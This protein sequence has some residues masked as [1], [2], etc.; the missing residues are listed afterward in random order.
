MAD[1]QIEVTCL[2]CQKDF[3]VPSYEQGRV[4]D[5]PRCYGFV[6]V[7][8]DAPTSPDV[9]NTED[10]LP[11]ELDELILRRVKYGDKS[12]LFEIYS[13]PDFT[14]Y[15]LFDPWTIEQTDDFVCSQ[16][17]IS[18][19]DTGVPFVL[20][21]VHREDNKVIGECQLSICPTFHRQ[22]E[23]GFGLNL[24]YA[25]RG[26]ATKMVNATLRFGFQQL[27]LHRITAAADVR[28]ERSWRL[29]ERL[30]MRREAHFVH[31]TYA[32]DEWVDDYVYAM[33]DEE[34]LARNG[35]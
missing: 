23:M 13:N 7:P 22:G 10:A 31:R 25:G 30:G 18:A 27:R 2:T 29:M 3:R 1:S 20:V 35:T 21:A 16:Y 4:V 15:Q 5:C 6:D 24:A 17:K 19:G 34:W 8:E 28:N 12:D 14:R 9:S 33:L 32:R 11:I 26:L